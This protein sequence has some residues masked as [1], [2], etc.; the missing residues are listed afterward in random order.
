VATDEGR[1]ST[2]GSVELHGTRGGRAARALREGRLAVRAWVGRR[3]GELWLAGC[4][5]VGASVV[6]Y[7]ILRWG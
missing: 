5:L 4:G 6:C 2:V 1:L 3:L 7:V